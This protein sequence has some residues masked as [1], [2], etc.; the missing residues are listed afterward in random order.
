V[1]LEPGATQEVSVTLSKTV[2]AAAPEPPPETPPPAPATPAAAEVSS[3]V[4]SNVVGYVLLGIAGVGA[5]VG[6]IF[7]VK[8]L[9]EKSEFNSGS[10]TNDQADTVEKDALIADMA[11]GAALTLGVTGV[12]LLLSGG[13]SSDKAQSTMHVAKLQILPA[14]TPYAHGGVGAG[15][16]LRF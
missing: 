14:V 12:V 1:E 2:V 15:A 7:G 5:G 10:K 4:H 11:F 13:G 8:A 3:E 16:T 9:Q 6:T